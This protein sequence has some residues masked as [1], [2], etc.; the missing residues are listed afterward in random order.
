MAVE[1]RDG[2][3][4][5]HAHLEGDAV[6]GEPRHEGGGDDI[7]GVG[8]FGQ[9]LV[10]FLVVLVGGGL[11]GLVEARAGLEADGA[12]FEVGEERGVHACT[13]LVDN[14]RTARES[15]GGGGGGGGGEKGQGRGEE[16]E[17]HAVV[18]VEVQY[19]CEDGE[20]RVVDDD[21]ALGVFLRLVVAA[22]VEGAHEVLAADLVLVLDPLGHG[23]VHHGGRVAVVGRLLRLE[24]VEKFEV[25]LVFA[26]VLTSRHALLELLLLAPYLFVVG[27][28]G[29]CQLHPPRLGEVVAE[30][31]LHLCE[32]EV[33]AFEGGHVVGE[34]KLTPFGAVEAQIR[35]LHHDELL[36]V[37]RDD[38]NVLH[39]DGGGGLGGRVARNNVAVLVDEDGTTRAEL[40]ERVFEE[41]LSELGVSVEVL[42]VWREV[43][44]FLNLFCHSVC[45]L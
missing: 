23:L 9:L 35:A 5:P 3:G 39:A 21:A 34:S 33:D 31:L 29:R 15:R 19:L 24:L 4:L 36:A 25:V 30:G 43:F 13:V 1:R 18:L 40:A 11:H 26:Q 8:V 42:G 16:E 17:A 32:V 27:Q 44:E 2:A 41:L 10:E 45:C 28:L 6:L 7:V 37:G 20:G 38:D 22:R 12:V 14:G